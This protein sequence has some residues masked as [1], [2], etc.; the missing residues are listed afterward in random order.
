LLF[1]C[2]LYLILKLEQD[3]KTFNLQKPNQYSTSFAT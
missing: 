1:V 3:K 2:Y